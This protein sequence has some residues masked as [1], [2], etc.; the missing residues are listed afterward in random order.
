V[1]VNHGGAIPQD[2]WVFK[3]DDQG[4]LL[5]QHSFGRSD[6]D[7]FKD[8]QPTSDG[9][10]ILT[11][12]TDS[13]TFIGDQLWI[14]KVD[15]NGD[16]QWE[17]RYGGAASEWGAVVL[18]KPGGG[19]IIAGTTGSND[20]DVTGNHGQSDIWLLN[21]NA[22]GYLLWQ[23]CYG[24]TGADVANSMVETTDR[25]GYVIAGSS[26]SADGQVAGNY[27]NYDG[28][29]IALDTLGSLEWTNFLGGT[30]SDQFFSLQR[31][32]SGGEGYI[33]AGS[34]VSSDHDV[35]AN[36]GQEDFWISFIDLT[37][38]LVWQKNMGGTSS[39]NARAVL[40]TLDDGFI[41]A[42]YTASSNG[43]VFFNH[44]YEDAWILK[45][46]AA[47]EGIP[48]YYFTSANGNWNN[49]A[50][51]VGNNVPPPGAT[52]VIKHIVTGNVN[53][54]CQALKLEPGGQLNIQPGT[55]FIIH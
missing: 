36:F 26:S 29:I 35:K 10:F 43:Y 30:Q 47:G 6:M 33:L 34:S 42:G 55:S 21:L 52:V 32:F 15:G 14:V 1:T 22:F 39:D 49:P 54:N 46:S 38:S 5:W 31:A 19:F 8:V 23:K 13:K 18:Q 16:P 20:G 40:Q 51:W 17:Q 48:D 53:I 4:K 2:G 12:G 7:Y 11:G 24:G 9:G 28:L 45:L 44:G 37:G 27:G 50:T 41:V 3:V 25:S